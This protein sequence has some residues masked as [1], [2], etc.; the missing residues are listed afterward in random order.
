MD[1]RISREKLVQLYQVE[2]QFF[3]ELEE[4]GLLH[5]T[6]ENNIKY[7]LFEDLPLFE[8]L[9][10]WHYDLDVNVAGLEVL[11]HVMMKLSELQRENRNLRN[12]M[13]IHFNKN[14]EF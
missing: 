12:Q 8:K 7:I 13:S 6:T 4:Y 1:E 11:Q 10:N 3:D 9:A 2:I 5:V 14:E